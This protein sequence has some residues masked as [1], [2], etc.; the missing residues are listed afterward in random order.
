[1]GCAVNT[2]LT[3]WVDHQSRPFRDNNGDCGGVWQGPIRLPWLGGHGGL[4]LP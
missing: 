2:P 3:D 4:A 1:M